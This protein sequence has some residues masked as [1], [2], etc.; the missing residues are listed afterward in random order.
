MFTSR[1][2]G[3]LAAIGVYYYAANAYLDVKWWVQVVPLALTVPLLWYIP[4]LADDWKKEL[5]HLLG[6]SGALVL[7][8]GSLALALY[9]FTV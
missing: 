3:T 1:I 6:S 7:A 9:L 2:V 8:V 4:R 5:V